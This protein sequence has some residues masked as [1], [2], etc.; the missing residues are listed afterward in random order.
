MTKTKVFASCE[1]GSPSNL[2]RTRNRFCNVFLSLE[3][4]LNRREQSYY[5]T[6]LPDRKL[7]ERVGAL[8]TN[9]LL[10]VRRKALM[11]E[12]TVGVAGTGGKQVWG[13]RHERQTKDE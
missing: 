10:A 1:V 6:L 7:H 11:K 9:S 5:D 4:A 13:S 3:I 8:V 2:H 12:I